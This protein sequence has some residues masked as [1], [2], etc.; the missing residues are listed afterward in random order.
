MSFHVV[1]FMIGFLAM[2]AMPHMLCGLFKVRFISPFGYG[3]RDNLLFALVNVVLALG[4]FHFRYGIG[5]LFSHG[6]IVGAGAV[7]VAFLVS[8]R[9]FYNRFRI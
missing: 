7:L 2:N 9:F 5:Q 3:E 1:D 8:G 4:L 6:M